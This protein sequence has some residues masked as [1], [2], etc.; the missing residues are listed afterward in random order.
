[1]SQHGRDDARIDHLALRLAAVATLISAALALGLAGLVPALVCLLTVILIGLVG[2]VG[3]VLMPGLASGSPQRTGIALAGVGVLIAATAG[4]GPGALFTGELTGPLGAAVAELALPSG[5]PIGLLAALAAGGLV[6]VSVELADRR[7]V[8]SAL[9]LGTAVLGLASV[10]APGTHLLP[11]LIPGW[12]AAL[13]ALTRLAA[14]ATTTTGSDAT[15]VPAMERLTSAGASGPRAVAHWQVFPVLAVIAVSLT[16]LT[17][18]VVSGVASIGERARNFGAAGGFASENGRSTSDYLGGGMDLDTRGPLDSRPVLDVPTGSPRLW[19]AGTLDQYTGRAWLATVSPAGLPTIVLGA[20][21]TAAVVDRSEPPAP[22][23][24]SRTDQVR[25]RRSQ[26]TQILAPG[27]LLS[28]TSPTL[29]LGGNV[30]ASAGDRLAMLGSA[31]SGRYQVRSHLLPAVDDAAAASMLTAGTGR[32]PDE[33]V[34]P[35]WT[36]L[37][38]QVPQRVLQLGRALVA[39]AP[40]RL[41]AVRAIEAELADRMTYT[42]DSPVPPPG[43]DAADDVLFVSHSGFCEQFAT[44]EVVL[45]RAAGIPARMAVGFAGGEPGGDGFRTV[46]RSDAHAWVEVWFPEVG[47]VTSDPTPAADQATRTWWQAFGDAVR[48]WFDHPLAWIG[49]VLLV[50]LLAVSGALLFRRGSRAEPGME[51]ADRQVD[52]DLA[53][54]F[55]RLEADLRAEGRPR[56][57]NETVAALARRLAAERASP[58]QAP[59]VALVAALQVLERALYAAQSPS[60]PESLAAAGAIDRRS[61]APAGAPPR[62]R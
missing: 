46:R 29:T 38:Q 6:A 13:F 19:R 14:I 27:R 28:L 31:D 17:L 7:A 39:G 58:G 53:A 18:A 37:P 5:F 54:A 52:P 59:E 2:L 20:G 42:L 26:T 35:R 50:I 62:R 56:A 10:A 55:L 30:F 12:P 9:V 43:A 23:T 25:P 61:D 4:S 47:W 36:M 1:M 16:V 33:S 44:A 32:G 8:Q 24:A 60:R 51:R 15:T 57:P 22:A 21:G 48:S 45:L 3:P 11:A 49:T 34:D 40:S 41:A